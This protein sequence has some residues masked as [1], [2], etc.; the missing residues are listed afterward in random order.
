[1]SNLRWT[2][3]VCDAKGTVVR[4]DG[5]IRFTGMNLRVRLTAPTSADADKAHTVFQKMAS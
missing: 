5:V 3:L 1:L 2:N 4:S